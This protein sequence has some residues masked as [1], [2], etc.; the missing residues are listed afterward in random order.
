VS[1]TA[2]ARVTNPS[3]TPTRSDW[4]ILLRLITYVRPYLPHLIGAVAIT[5]VVSALGP[6]RPWLF[7]HAIDA[8]V[9]SNQ[10]NQVLLFTA[11]IAATLIFHG[12]LQVVQSYVLQWIGQQTLHDMRRSVFHHILHLRFRTIDTTP[13]GRLVTRATNDVEALNELFSSGVV[14]IISD[15]LVLVWILVFMLATDAELTLYALVVIPL[16]LVAASIFRSK[17]RK[18]YSAIRV[19]VAR[20][21]A[22]LNE[23]IQGISTIHLFNIHRQQADRFDAINR[24]HTRL[25]LRTVTYYAS[26]FPVVEFLSVLALCLVL[27]AAFGR[28]VGGSMSIGTVVSFLMYGE[29]FFRPVRD[30]TEKYNVLQTATTASERI[31]ALLDEPTADRQSDDES[32]LPAQP[33]R[34]RI[35]FER[36][37][38]SYDDK[39]TVLD[40]ISFEIPAGA[41]VAIVGATGSGK[42]TIAN[43][44][45]KFYEP[46][47]GRI[48]IDGTEL[49]R[50][51][52]ISHRQ[53]CAIVLQE[54]FL[55]SRS[56]E[57]NIQL[58][59]SLSIE[60]LWDRLRQTHPLLVERLR[61]ESTFHERGGSL[62]G[63][64]RQILAL[65]RA[66]AGNPE[67]LILD[68]ATAHVDSE[69][70][71]TVMDI[72]EEIRGTMTIVS[73]AH[74]L[75]TIRS[76]DTIVVLHQGKIVEQGTHQ[77]LLAR[78]GYYATLYKLQQF[79]RYTTVDGSAPTIEAQRV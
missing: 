33:I 44:L 73:I 13:V 68:E 39:T 53:R 50:I 27:Y 55:F 58:G 54:A 48:T 51:E 40:N 47:Q 29:M 79:D 57:E 42:S 15:V 43:L 65:L 69:T 49:A 1:P 32:V 52:T 24:E 59:R 78:D 4:R 19:Q 31:F 77:E 71:R 21:N 64:E 41:F 18:V 25:Q 26:F 12:A 20:M 37:G 61:R 36:V 28:T 66:L 46:Q 30:L 67:L 2:A 22:F 17:V 74:R 6:L 63:G 35:A 16:L 11:I 3:A 14:M 10:W 8:A 60:H 9:A 75:A 62:S 5:L 76:A 70:E 56:A 23:F 7:R 38:F 45:L 34:D 72:I